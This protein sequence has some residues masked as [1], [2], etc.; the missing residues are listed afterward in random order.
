MGTVYRRGAGWRAEVHK[1]GQRRS[2]TFYTKREAL[3]WIAKTEDELLAGPV[4]SPTMRTVL[5]RYADEPGRSRWDILRLGAFRRLEWA[6]LPVNQVTAKTIAAWRDV[7]LTQV[8]PGTVIRE[9]TLLRSVFEAARRDW[10]LVK[11]NP[12]KDVRRPPAPEPRK[13]LISDE[14][15]D[16]MLR[17]FGY[18]GEVTTVEH[19]TAVAMLLALETGMRAGE[20]L[21]LKWPDVDLPRRVAKLH[22]SKTGPGRDVPLSTRAVELFGVLKDK[23]LVRARTIRKGYVFHVTG[24]TLDT[25]FRRARK[26]AALSGFTFHDTRATAATRLSAVLD[27]RDLARMLGHSDL[28]SLLVYYRAPAES[29]AAKLG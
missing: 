2:S 11:T 29:I 8:A 24:K 21:A 4:S 25:L 17:S 5:D 27:V 1:R 18:Q 12:V 13:R 3:D 26:R 6:A 20:L 10:E 9:L 16:E 28:S 23:R 19:E 22:R 14:E 15:R 7:R